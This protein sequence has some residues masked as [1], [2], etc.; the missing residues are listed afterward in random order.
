LT[1]AEEQV[2]KARVDAQRAERR[3][4]G[5]RSPSRNQKR[6]EGYIARELFALSVHEATVV[7]L[8][9]DEAAAGT[10]TWSEAARPAQAAY[11]LGHDQPPT[12]G[13]R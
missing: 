4:R 9:A 12:R 7:A 5:S 6:L 11:Q 3:A 13:R 8:L 2:I 1:S 10:L